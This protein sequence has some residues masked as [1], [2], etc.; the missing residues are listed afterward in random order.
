VGGGGTRNVVDIPALAGTD[1]VLPVFR[2]LFK[3]I[4]QA[5]ELLIYSVAACWLP[6]PL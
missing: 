6:T 4:V 1:I 5:T 2:M 3:Q